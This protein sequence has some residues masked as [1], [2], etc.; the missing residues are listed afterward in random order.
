VVASVRLVSGDY[1]GKTVRIKAPAEPGT[2]RLRYHN[3]HSRA[4]LYETELIV[5]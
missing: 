4:V 3:G 5:E 2:Y 1:D